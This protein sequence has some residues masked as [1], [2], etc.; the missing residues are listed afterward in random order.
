MNKNV[1]RALIAATLVL[2]T[3]AFASSH[4]LASTQQRDY[5]QD[6]VYDDSILAWLLGDG[7]CPVTYP[8]DL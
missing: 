6:L 2:A 5:C 8:V 1:V 4:H 3:S 7:T